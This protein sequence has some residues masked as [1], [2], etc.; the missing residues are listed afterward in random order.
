[1]GRVLGFLVVGMDGM[2][3]EDILNILSCDEE[4][5]IDVLVWYELFKC[6]L[7]FLLLVC[8]K[9][10]FGLFLVERGVYGVFLLVFYYR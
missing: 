1:M 8:L 2:N 10:D 6:C 5:L 9:Y 7:L 3:L 4:F